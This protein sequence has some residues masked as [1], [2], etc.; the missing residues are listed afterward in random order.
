[1]VNAVM[2][3]VVTSAIAWS[4]ATAGIRSVKVTPL[5]GSV[6]YFRRGQQEQRTR[7]RRIPGE[8]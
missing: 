5:V 3:T 8:T 7:M 2:A 1:M 6:G 4:V